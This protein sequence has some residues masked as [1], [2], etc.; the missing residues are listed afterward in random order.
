MAFVI[1]TSTIGKAFQVELYADDG[2]ER[3]FLSSYPF[4]TGNAVEP[5]RGSKVHNFYVKEVKDLKAELS[6]RLAAHYRDL[7][8]AECD[9]RAAEIIGRGLMRTPTVH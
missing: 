6:R 9:Q 2:G 8:A 4:H 3:E 1:R 7:S 5:L